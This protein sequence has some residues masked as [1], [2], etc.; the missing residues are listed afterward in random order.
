M[1]HTP[2]EAL[3]ESNKPIVEI[4][5]EMETLSGVEWPHEFGMTNNIYERIYV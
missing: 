5:T 4:M 3:P 1:R 2:N